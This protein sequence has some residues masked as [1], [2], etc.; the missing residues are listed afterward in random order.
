MQSAEQKIKK[1]FDAYARRVNDSLGED[2][3][4]DVQGVVDSFAP[5]FVESSAHGG[6]YSLGVVAYEALTGE[7]PFEGD[8]KAQFSST[9]SAPTSTTA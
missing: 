4:I 6:L 3:V 8:R 5:Y 9:S 1:F 2:P 7:L